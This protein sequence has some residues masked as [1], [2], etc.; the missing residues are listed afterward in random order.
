MQATLSKMCSLTS[1]FEGFCSGLL[2]SIKISDMLRNFTSQ[3]NP[4]VVA[5][6]HC[7][8]FKMLFSAK[9]IYSWL[10]NRAWENLR[11]MAFP[12]GV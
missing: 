10:E 1:I 6:K 2:L 9:F 4:L 11:Q 5:A 3:E 8:V 12:V 7:K